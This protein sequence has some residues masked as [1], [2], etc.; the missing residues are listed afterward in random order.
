[1]MRVVRLASE[2]RPISGYPGAIRLTFQYPIKD[3]GRPPEPFM[4]TGRPGNGDLIYF[5]Y[6]DPD[7]DP[8]LL[9]VGYHHFG[10]SNRLSEPMR[11]DHKVAHSAVIAMGSLLPP[12]DDPLF[13]NHQDWLPLKRLLYVKID[14]QVVFDTEEDFHPTPPNMISVGMNLIGA[15]NE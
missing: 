12:S 4:A 7:N 5:L 10:G 3:L 13:R 2:S 11:L 1:S 9:V 14:G 8:D 15:P 6:V